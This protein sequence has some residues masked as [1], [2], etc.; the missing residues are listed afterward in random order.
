LLRLPPVPDGNRWR[1]AGSGLLFAIRCRY[2]SG[3]RSF[4]L[5]APSLLLESGGRKP[6]EDTQSLNAGAVDSAQGYREQ[7]LREGRGRQF[8]GTA[9]LWNH[10]V[11]G[12]SARHVRYVPLDEID[13]ERRDWVPESGWPL[14]RQT[15]QPFYEQAQEFCG[16]GKFDYRPGACQTGTEDSQPWQ[17]EKIESVVSQFGSS[18]IFLERYRREL[19]CDERVTVILRAVLLQLQMDPLSRAITSA[20]AGTLNGRKFQIRAR[21]FVLAAAA[22]KTP[23]FCSFRTRCS[24]ADSATRTTWSDAALWTTLRSSWEHS[25][26]PPARFLDKLDFTIS[27][28]LEG[29]P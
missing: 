24:P 4:P 18:D 5:R 25:S 6:A 12:E 15:I 1:H 29:T 26:P 20:Q 7:T 14:S 28:M 27:T 16:I 13:F 2:H 23:A 9:N 3:P 10:E 17:T 8:G 21:A 22:W 11:R 19:V